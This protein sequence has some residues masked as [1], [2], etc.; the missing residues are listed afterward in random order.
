MI[1]VTRED[2][3]VWIYW[4]MLRVFDIVRQRLRR[5]WLIDE[6]AGG[7]PSVSWDPQSQNKIVPLWWYYYLLAVSFSQVVQTVSGVWFAL[8]CFP[9]Y[10][11][12]SHEWYYVCVSM[13]LCVCVC[14]TYVCICTYVCVQYIY[15]CNMY[16]SCMCTVIAQGQTVGSPRQ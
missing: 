15:V 8:V 14:N 11:S 13:Y 16:V 9:I 4:I 2:W 10:V 5:F 12:H 6:F 1:K 7:G 3:I